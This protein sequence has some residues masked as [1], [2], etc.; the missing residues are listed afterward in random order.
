MMWRCK[1]ERK[2][3]RERGRNEDRKKEELNVTK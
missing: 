2:E 3:G 1:K